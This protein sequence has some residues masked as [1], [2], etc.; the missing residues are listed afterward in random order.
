MAKDYYEVLGVLKTA[1][2][3]EIK[4]AYRKL[5]LQY[6]PDR[7]K[8]KE[9]ESKFK[10]VTHA[11]EVLSD[12]QKRQT[13]DQFGQAAFES[14]GA[15]AG[16]GPFGGAGGPFGQARSGQYGPFTY[17]YTTSGG[18]ADFDFGGF[19]DP[20]E[21]FEQFFGGAARQ[22]R[23]VYQVTIDFM[24]AVKGTE[25]KVTINGKSQT[26]K[27][28]AG[29]DEGSRI[30][31]DDYDVV[32]DVKSDGRFRREGYDIISEID[33][34]FS[35]LAIG[36]EVPVETIWGEIKFRVPAG[37]QPGSLIRLQGK[38][39]AHVRGSGRGDHYVRINLVIPKNLTSHQKQL[40][41]EF[42]AAGKK[43]SWF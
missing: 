33:L 29:V 34:S 35:Q 38:G 31:F 9:A 10:E 17:T 16:Q 42:E 30:R 32:V 28:P 25:K 2:S 15:G 11:Y 19:S 18:G 26:I 40:L 12:P 20:F 14:G 27:I 43:K 4:R 13:Y 37:T 6:H 8:T 21:I 5:A 39:V 7:N 24:E 36:A 3:D 22:R 41:E 23:P 1:S